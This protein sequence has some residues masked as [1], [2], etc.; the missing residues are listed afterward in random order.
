MDRLTVKWPGGETQEFGNLNAD[1]VYLLHEGEDIEVV[2][3]GSSGD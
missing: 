3:V 1:T 2:G